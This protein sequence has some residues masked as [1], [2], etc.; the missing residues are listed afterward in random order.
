MGA[1]FLFILLSLQMGCL[2]RQIKKKI[3]YCNR[4]TKQCAREREEKKERAEA[5]MMVR[6]IFDNFK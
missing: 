5:S 1:L 2:I 4:K 3:K 6:Y